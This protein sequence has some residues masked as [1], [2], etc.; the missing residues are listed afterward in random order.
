MLI[1]P[2]DILNRIRLAASYL[3]RRHRPGGF[4]YEI[5]VGITNRCNLD[6]V[7]CPQRQSRKKKGAIDISLLENILDQATRYVDTVDL[8]FDGEPFLH[9]AWPE[10][11]QSCRRRGISPMLETNA[12]L[13]DREL[14][15]EILQ[16][17]IGSITFSIDAATPET[18]SRLKPSGDYDVA[19]ANVEKFLREAR[20]IKERPY[21]Q[22]QFVL[23]DENAGEA[24]AFLRQWRGK[25]AD[26]VH[27]KPML[28][29]AGSVG[30]VPPSAAVYRPCIFLWTSLSIHWD[31]T[32]P[33]CCLEIEGR[34]KM[35]DAAGR[36]LK[37]IFNNEKFEHVRRL[38][39]SG[40][41]REDPICRGCDVPS[42]SWPFVLGSAFVG[43][44]TRR[45]L[46]NW[47]DRF[48]LL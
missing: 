21:I 14:R 33:L 24:E 12:L 22:V 40:R 25:G 10:C 35:G 32:V 6:C 7:F 30:N 44:L 13:L 45:K 17:G 3:R 31:G 46:I 47:F 34:T 4:P 5:Q 8:S 28:N 1:L 2:P 29:F 37:D 18:Y 27:G 43:D 41:H 42:V 38:H 39:A 23:T 19:V 11:V 15:R 26:A 9:P 48:H 16:A 36:P 20:R